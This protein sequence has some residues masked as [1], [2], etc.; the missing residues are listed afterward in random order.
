MLIAGLIII[1]ALFFGWN[2]FHSMTDVDNL[3]VATMPYVADN[4]DIVVT[5]NQMANQPLPQPTGILPIWLWLLA[6]AVWYFL[7]WINIVNEWERRPVLLFGR[8]VKTLGAGLGFVEPIFYSTLD[9]VPVQDIVIEVEVPE[10]QTKDNVGIALTGVLTYRISEDRVKDSVVQVEDVYDSVLE[11]SF[12][13]LT[14]VA[15]TNE[16]DQLLEHR[17]A[18][19]IAIMAKLAER[20]AGWGVVVNAF[21]L[22]SFSIND[23]AVEQAIAMKARAAKEGA[24]ELVRAEMQEK[25]A[26]AL[27]K[28]ATTYTEEG[29]WLKGTEV[30]LELCRSGQNNTILIPTDITESLAKLRPLISG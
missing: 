18:F 6:M 9:D 3:V 20:V 13:T 4:G 10:V 21:E 28:A 22:K 16:L 12:S 8:Y 5:G 2:H 23:E 19:C 15:A 26:E 27:N 14:D 25:I 24:A 29:R 30:M 1:T 17:D 7:C 11:R